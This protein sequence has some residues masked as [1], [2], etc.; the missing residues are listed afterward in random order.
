MCFKRWQ[1]T[2]LIGHI[3]TT[4]FVPR[5]ETTNQIILEAFVNN[6]LSGFDFSTTEACSQ[7][8]KAFTKPMSETYKMKVIMWTL[9]AV[10]TG[11]V[12]GADLSVVLYLLGADEVKSRVS[13]CFQA[14]PI[15]TKSI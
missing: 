12:H 3:R 13:R 7:S 4:L 1:E 8:L 9:R 2:C 14:T 15:A 10:L 11:R 6:V 5:V